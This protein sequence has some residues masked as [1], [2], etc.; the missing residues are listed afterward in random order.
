MR[1]IKIVL[2]LC[3]VSAFASVAAAQSEPRIGTW[4]M[5]L[6]KSKFVPGPAPK[7]LT[8][9][10][11]MTGPNLTALTGGTDQEG[12]PINP[13]MNKVVITLDGKDHPTPTT[14]TAYDSTAW[15]RIDANT[16]NIVRKKDGKQTQTAKN[17]LSKD[18]K[19]LTITTRGV[20]AAGQDFNNV[21][22][23]E[24]Q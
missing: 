16:W 12:K 13:D 5:N 1:S 7:T 17:V 23:Y 2:A 9:T 6:A 4:K 3:L 8:L 15:N 20:N 10:Y 21:V 11:E 24:R 14:N 18:G 22:V 19:T